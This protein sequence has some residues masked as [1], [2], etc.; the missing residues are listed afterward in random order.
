MHKN[1]P[2]AASSPASQFLLSL[3]L[4]FLN[5]NFVVVAVAVA[6][7][8]SDLL[9]CFCGRRFF[10]MVTSPGPLVAC[11]WMLVCCCCTPTLPWPDTAAFAASNK[12]ARRWQKCHCLPPFVSPCA[13]NFKSYKHILFA[14]V[15]FKLAS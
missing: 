15:E 6:A 2:V 14:F 13:G 10:P 4:F 7:S 12:C 1:S 5:F 8:A 9:C 3:S 11:V